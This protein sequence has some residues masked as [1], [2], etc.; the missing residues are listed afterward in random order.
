[1]MDGNLLF[2]E[3]PYLKLTVT[4]RK[5][6]V[7]RT[8]QLWFAYDNDGKLYF[9][10]HKDSQ[11]W[12]NVQANPKV[13]VEVL[14]VTF[15]GLGRLVPDKL[16]VVYELFKGK[17]GRDQV[18]RWYSGKHGSQRQAVEIEVGRVIGKRPETTR[19]MEP[20]ISIS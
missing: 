12:K 15:Q 20:I 5:S 8:V 11:W 9:L 14:E 2:E 10:A 17:Y 18:E 16:G 6:H 7:K 4:G 13:E 19:P 3:A 1:M